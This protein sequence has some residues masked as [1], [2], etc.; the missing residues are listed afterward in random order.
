MFSKYNLVK[1][2]IICIFALQNKHNSNKWEIGQEK[3]F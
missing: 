1:W 3:V 2:R